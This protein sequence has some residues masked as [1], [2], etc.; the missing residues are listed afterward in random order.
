MPT[1]TT[2]SNDREMGTVTSA[3]RTPIAFEPTGGGELLG[4]S[5]SPIATEEEVSGS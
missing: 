2:A 5:M 3:D 4:N 1:V